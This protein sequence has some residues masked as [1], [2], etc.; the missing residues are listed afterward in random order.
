MGG[1]KTMSSGPT[2][3]GDTYIEA[4]KKKYINVY[5]D[6]ND[7]CSYKGK[8]LIDNVITERE[9]LCLLCKYRKPLDIPSV[10][11]EHMD[12]RVS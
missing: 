6:K 8:C 7:W 12:R 1:T 10:L 2:L 9:F 4:T 11:Q 5:F 3:T